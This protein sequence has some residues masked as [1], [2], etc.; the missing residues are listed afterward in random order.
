VGIAA[1]ALG[2]IV[3]VTMTALWIRGAR[4][5]DQLESVAVVPAISSIAVLPLN[6]RMGDPEQ[7]YFVEGM[8]EALITELSKIRALKVISRTSTMPYGQTDKPL[9]Q[10][11]RE[12]NVDAVIEGSVLR[13]GERVRIT[14]HLVHGATDRHLWAQTFER[15]RR[16][17]LALQSDVA[18]AIAHEIRVSL[19]PQE[20]RVLASARL[21]DPEAH[22]A[23]LKGRHHL[24]KGTLAGLQNAREYFRQ[25]LDLDPTYAP[26]YVGLADVYNRLAIQGR[27][28]PREVYPLAKA[29]LVKALEL[30]EQ[31]AEAH[32]LHGVVKFRFDWDWE[33]AERDLRRAL[34]L[35]PNNTRAHLGYGTHLLMTGRLEEALA[36][37]AKFQELDPLSPFASQNLAWHLYHNRRY[38]D[39]ISRLRTA[40]HLDPS[41]GAAYLLL[42]ESYAAMGAHGEAIAACDTALNL[43][44][45]DNNVLSRCGAVYAV[46][47]KHQSAVRLFQN[48]QLRASAR[49]YVDPYGLASFAAAMYTAPGA[50]DRV[51][52][53]LARAYEDRSANLCALKVNPAFGR[54]SADPRFQELLRRMHFP[55]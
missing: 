32:A 11:A 43:T 29:A 16:S 28:L 1:A 30:D 42:G 24:G 18:R 33:G 46:S 45:N 22:R 26:A 10:V 15:E 27:H 12:L 6:N 49:G 7:D 50:S 55:K 23:Y 21:V 36:Y 2:T 19:T 3:V 34:E 20:Q 38:H 13:E 8:H 54:V 14:V 40:L 48:L 17:V 52:Q 37:S 41:S 5:P 39:A 44:P 51:M 47:G 4:S 53:W 9:P 31:L 35:E 25:S